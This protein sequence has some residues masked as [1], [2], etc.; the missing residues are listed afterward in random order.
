MY[1]RG[2]EAC[3]FLVIW[4]MIIWLDVELFFNKYIQFLFIWSILLELLQVRPGS[5]YWTFDNCWN[6][7]NFHDWGPDATPVWAI[8]ALKELTVLFSS[9][10]LLLF[11]ILANHTDP[12]LASWC[13]LS[14]CPSVMLC[15][16]AHGVGIEGLK[17]YYWP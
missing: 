16:M 11:V 12:L 14:V 13:H 5:Q 6:K 17:L 1:T 7:Q 8:I 4:H 10:W 3:E 9:L 2:L 15:I